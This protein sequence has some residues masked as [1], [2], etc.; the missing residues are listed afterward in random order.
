MVRKILLI[1][2]I[3]IAVRGYCQKDTI[4]PIKPNYGIYFISDSIT[5]MS[6]EYIVKNNII[7]NGGIMQHWAYPLVD[8]THTYYACETPSTD[9]FRLSLISDLSEIKEALI[10]FEN[11]LITLETLQSI[12]NASAVA[13]QYKD[14]INDIAIIDKNLYKLN[15]NFKNFK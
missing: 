15:T 3:S 2:L 11:G 12:T 9:R 4:R 13:Q 7:K 5:F 6:N 1:I 10:N 14:L 8:S